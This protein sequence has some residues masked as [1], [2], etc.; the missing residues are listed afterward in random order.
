MDD[1][2]SEFLDV[3]LVGV[4]RDPYSVI[5]RDAVRQTLARHLEPS[6]RIG[7]L[8]FTL[9]YAMY[10]GALCGVLFLGPLW[11]KIVC[12][13]VAGI[14]MANLGTLGHDANS[15]RGLVGH[16][17]PHRAAERQPGQADRR[18]QPGD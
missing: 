4:V 9:D 12:S 13:L 2:S 17:K 6:T 18:L 16:A 7:L 3:T 14:K 8:H 11:L 15:V 5:A 1:G 10:V